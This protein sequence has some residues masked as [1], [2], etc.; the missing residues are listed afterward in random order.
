M[1][2]NTQKLVIYLETKLQVTFYEVRKFKEFELSLD[3]QTMKFQNF[4]RAILTRLDKDLFVFHV[5]FLNLW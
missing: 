1:A 3:L 5:S 4:V 2:Q